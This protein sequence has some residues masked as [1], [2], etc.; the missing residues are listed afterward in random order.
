[1][2][3]GNSP[4]RD[5]V[6]C[7]RPTSGTHNTQRSLSRN[8]FLIRSQRPITDNIFC[9]CV[10]SSQTAG[11]RCCCSSAPPKVRICGA[12]A[13]PPPPP[14]PCLTGRKPPGGCHSNCPT[15]RKK[16]AG[17]PNAYP[18]PPCIRMNQNPMGPRCDFDGGE[19]RGYGAAPNGTSSEFEPPCQVLDEMVQQPIDRYCPP[20]ARGGRSVGPLANFD[21][22]RFD[23]D[24]HRGGRRRNV[25]I[26]TCIDYD[27]EPTD[28]GE[29]RHTSAGRSRQHPPSSY[30]NPGSSRGS[31]YP[32]IQDQWNQYGG[33]PE[34]ITCPYRG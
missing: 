34:Y 28:G 13:P 23:R 18:V 8:C 19:A 15:K 27:Y 21:L 30:G 14:P 25:S 24:A 2:L 1:M 17:S 20:P 3:M 7:G 32:P 33:E 5:Q 31:R 12:S 11:G 16:H 6:G 29:R 10:P 9:Q 26:R 22:D 4:S